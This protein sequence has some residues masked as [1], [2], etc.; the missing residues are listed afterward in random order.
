MLAGPGVRERFNESGLYINH[1]LGLSVDVWEPNEVEGMYGALAATLLAFGM[2]IALLSLSGATTCCSKGR[3]VL[4]VCI[5]ELFSIS[6]S[7]RF[8]LSQPN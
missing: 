8:F 2:S 4:A 1:D 6:L 3:L 5:Q 7:N